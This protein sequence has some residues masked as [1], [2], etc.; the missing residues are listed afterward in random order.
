M[1]LHALIYQLCKFVY[2]GDAGL[3]EWELYRSFS[4]VLRE[5]SLSGAARVLGMAQPTVGRHIAALEDALGLVLFTRSQT[6]FLPTEA[7]LALQP[8]ARAMEAIAATLERTAGSLGDGVR[9]TVRVS[10]SEWVGV[11]VMPAVIAALR[12][13]H[14][15]VR[16]ELVIANHVQDLLHREA[17]IAVRVTRPTQEQLIARRVGTIE[18]G[19]HA[20]AGYLA[21]HGEPIE[22]ADLSSHTL[23]GY[24]RGTPFVRDALQQWPQF[25]HANLSLRTDNDLAQLALIRAGAGIGMC[26]AALA[27]RS[28]DLVRVLPAAFAISLESWVTMHEDLRESASC[29]ATFDAL[30]NAMSSLASPASGR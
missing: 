14:P 5:G 8:H 10:V 3:I 26:P 17:D 21:R 19:L 24:D 12:E 23:I 18:W 11:E 13:R 6:G 7:A 22:L 2:L 20:S 29:R 25:Q 30:V 16:I 28:P 1:E 9:G 4:H 15:D 27:C